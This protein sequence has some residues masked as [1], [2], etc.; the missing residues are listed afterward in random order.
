MSLRIKRLEGDETNSTKYLFNLY[1]LR[2]L[3]FLLI[4]S[5]IGELIGHSGTIAEIIKGFTLPFGC[6]APGFI[7]SFNNFRIFL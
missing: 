1:Y 5:G 7:T 4:L 3:F 6:F 2:T